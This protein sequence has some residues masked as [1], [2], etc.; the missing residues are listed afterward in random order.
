MTEIEY[1]LYHHGVKG[2]KWGVRKKYQAWKEKSA[3]K[4]IRRYET[5]RAQN[6]LERKNWDADAKD[7]YSKPK[8]AKKLATKLASNKAA[9]DTSEVTN[10]YLIAV[11]KARKDKTYKNSSEYQRAK[12]DYG[13][14]QK[15]QLIYGAWG[16]HRINTLKNLGNSEKQAKARATAEV[17]LATV[18]T[19]AITA[20]YTAAV[21]RG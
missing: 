17:A 6:K 8:Q 13:K 4:R 3:N 7:D 15:Q 12:A 21:N 9:Y 2:M 19:L 20:L 18:G 14:E 10:K 11:Q 16:S 5:T 1:E